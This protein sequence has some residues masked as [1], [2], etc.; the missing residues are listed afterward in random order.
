MF[1]LDRNIDLLE[2]LAISSEAARVRG[3]YAEG[4]RLAREAADLAQQEGN[5]PVRAAMLRLLANQLLR[6]G[7]IEH[8][9]TAAGEAADIEVAGG[10][11]VGRAQSLTIQAMGYLDLGLAEEALQALAISLEIAQSLRDPE[12]LF[13]SYNRIGNA[14]SHL[15]K[16]SESRDFLRRA[17]PL[18]AGLGGEAKFCILNNLADNGANLAAQAHLEGNTAQ[19]ADAVEFGLRYV[20]DAI[21]LARAA[22]NPYREAISMGNFATLLAFS[23]DHPGAIQASTRSHAIAARNGY[24]SLELEAAFNLGRIAMLSGDAPNA[25]SR[26]EGLIPDLIASNEAPLLLACHRLLSDIYQQ[27]GQPDAALIHFKSYH[28]LESATRSTI[29]ETRSRMVTTMTELGAALIEAERANLE[30]RL[31]QMQLAELE[32]ERQELLLRTSDLDRKAHEDDLTGLKNRRFALG[33]LAN[34]IAA[35]PPDQSVFVAIAD[36][37]HFKSINDRLG[38]TAGDE[39][40]QKMAALLVDGV[41]PGDLVARLG[42]EEFLIAI[43]GSAQS[44]VATCNRLVASVQHADWPGGLSVTISVGLARAAPH[45]PVNAV[46]GHADGAL[47]RSKSGGRNRLT[48]DI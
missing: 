22:S 15:G 26:L 18:S 19:M 36:A 37:D 10:N 13:W 14:K 43:T 40:L 6:I 25:A 3:N 24:K 39:V 44:A 31:H 33:A 45:E 5:S 4:A 46:I 1:G 27:S 16:F 2:K 34:R 42:G 21:E 7:D 35:C 29:A 32:T 8:A 23:G 20:V 12:L 38:H 30:I 47:Y 28:R 17:L 11:A 48:V 41:E 9:V